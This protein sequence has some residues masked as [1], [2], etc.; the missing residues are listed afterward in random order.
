MDWSKRKAE[1]ITEKYD[2]TINFFIWAT[3]SKQ[4]YAVP[5]VE[6]TKPVYV[7][8]V[9]TK[10]QKPLTEG[11]SGYAALSAGPGV[12]LGAKIR[13]SAAP[14]GSVPDQRGEWQRDAFCQ[15]KQVYPRYL[16]NG[17]GRKGVGQLAR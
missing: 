9:Q 10:T 12:L 6:G 4:I 5:T 7:F 11:Y 14:A 13:P 15:C 3:D 17:S 16:E 1:D 8:D 2:Q